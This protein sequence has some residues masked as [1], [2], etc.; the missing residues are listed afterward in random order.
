MYELHVWFSCKIA[1]LWISASLLGWGNGCLN[2]A[3]GS[4]QLT[5]SRARVHTKH[6][7]NLFFS[8]PVPHVC[9]E[10][11][12]LCFCSLFSWLKK[13]RRKTRTFRSSFRAMRWLVVL[14]CVAR[15][16]F[17]ETN[18]HVALVP[19]L[20]VCR[21]LAAWNTSLQDLAGQ[22]QSVLWLSTNWLL[23]WGRAAVTFM[24]RTGRRARRMP[25]RGHPEAV[26]MEFLAERGFLPEEVLNTM[27]LRGTTWQAARTERSYRTLTGYVHVEEVEAAI[28]Y[29]GGHRAYWCLSATS[30]YTPPRGPANRFRNFFW[31]LWRW[32]RVAVLSDFFEVEGCF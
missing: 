8:E 10:I 15:F 25:R 24:V 27:Q 7:K 2:V 11:H 18:L 3:S 14:E 30:H 28:T 31:L 26:D 13:A 16:L 23:L 32:K 6:W 20:P 21:A 5:G 12:C 4:T 29:A 19:L 1:C 22:H 17:E 9:K